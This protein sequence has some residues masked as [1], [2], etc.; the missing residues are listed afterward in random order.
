MVPG[1]YGADGKDVVLSEATIAAA[2]NVQ[3]DPM[4][5]AVVAD[6][7]RLFGVSLPNAPN[8]TRRAQALLALWAGP[9]SW[10]L[11]ESAL[12][13][14]SALQ[15]RP[16]ALVDFDTMRDALN[17]GG[18]ALFD[19]SVSRVAYAVRGAGAAN[20]LAKSC[21]IDF[22]SRVFLPGHCAQSMLGRVNALYYRHVH[23]PAFTVMVARSLASDVWR[24]LC[25]AASTDGY[26]V[27]PSAAFEA[28]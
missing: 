5:T 27:E 6:V 23:A 24:G 17:A 11:I 18:G 28:D 21:P 10:L 2:W 14:E 13:N 12:R 25:V 15:K 7:E 9:R 1:H 22:D 26:D 16:L 19:V 4:R 8:A 20:V 3:G